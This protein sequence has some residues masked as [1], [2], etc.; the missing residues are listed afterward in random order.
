MLRTAELFHISKLACETI[1]KSNARKPEDGTPTIRANDFYQ[2][3]LPGI[4]HSEAFKIAY[5]LLLC[6]FAKA[7]TDKTRRENALE[8]LRQSRRLALDYWKTLESKTLAAVMF[9]PKVTAAGIG[10]VK[11]LFAKQDDGEE[12]NRRLLGLVDRFKSLLEKRHI[13]NSKAV[14]VTEK[15]LQDSTNALAKSLGACKKDDAAADMDRWIFRIG[16]AAALIGGAVAAL[17][18]LAILPISPEIPFEVAGVL[19]VI[20]GVV[21]M[22]SYQQFLADKV[23]TPI[24]Q[25]IAAAGTRAVGSKKPE[26]VAI[27]KIEPPLPAQKAA[28]LAGAEFEK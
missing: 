24:V 18:A 4:E 25:T 9:L 27:E 6:A 21:R 7:P 17:D 14:V 12:Y 16:A 26:V 15:L 20:W 13:E 5:E 2:Q 1:I 19:F 28:E 10:A 3:E 8:L 22:Q 23:I 11:I